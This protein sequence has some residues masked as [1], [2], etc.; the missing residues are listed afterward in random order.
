MHRSR[1]EMHATCTVATPCGTG[2]YGHRANGDCYSKLWA[3]CLDSSDNDACYYMASHDDCTCQ[4]GSCL[5]LV[6]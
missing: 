3:F 1:R 5:Q 6:Q 2:G 4:S